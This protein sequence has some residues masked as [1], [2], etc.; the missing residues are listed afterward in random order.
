MRVLGLAL[1][2][3]LAITPPIAVQASGPASNMRPANAGTPSNIV[4]A[5][6]GSGSG[7]HAGV[8]AGH[9]PTGRAEWNGRGVAPHW[10]PNRYYGGC[11]FYGGPPV[12]TYWVWVP[13][14]AV[15]DYPFGDWRGPTGG[16]GNP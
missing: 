14:S 9:R 6:D 3:V 10:G 7:G 8:I 16:W 4:R 13:G 1:F 15:F 2:S 11:C 12:P 5:W